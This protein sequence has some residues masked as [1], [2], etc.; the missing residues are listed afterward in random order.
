MR[1]GCVGCLFLIILVLGAGFVLGG[2][3]VLSTTIFNVPERLP[4]ADWTRW[5]G[6]RAQQKIAEVIR[7]D[8]GKSPRTDPVV[9]T[10]REINAFLAHHLEESE[11]MP[12]SPLVVELAP[13]GAVIQGKTRLRALL[14]GIPFNY[15]ADALPASQTE[16][17]VWVMIRG[18]VRF[19]PGRGKER[20]VLRIEP[21]RFRVGTQEVGPWLL[22][23]LIGPRLLRWSLP[24][25]I[26]E[27]SV[28]EGRVFV[29]TR[30][31]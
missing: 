11:A 10:E 22:S 7:R 27:L 8:T 17:E 5:D 20:G 30:A 25:V 12:F 1:L 21:T 26:E 3:L 29:I 16:R 13:R 19:E 24:K 28:E 15:L 14:K 18:R 2:G 6:Q 9:F 31:G 4:T 23:R